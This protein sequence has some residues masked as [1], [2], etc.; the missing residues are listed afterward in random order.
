MAE[1]STAPSS[2]A[3]TASVNQLVGAGLES[4]LCTKFLA[5]IVLHDSLAEADLPGPPAAPTRAFHRTRALASK[6][7]N[8]G[9]ERLR[10]GAASLVGAGVAFA[11][12]VGS[13]VMV[14]NSPGSHAASGSTHQGSHTL[15]ASFEPP[16]ESPMAAHAKTHAS[17][18]RGVWAA[19]KTMGELKWR[20]AHG[21][22]AYELAFYRGDALAL[23]LT[24][25][26]TQLSVRVR[27]AGSAGQ[28][29]VRLAPGDY[30]WYVWPVI[31]GA[32]GPVAIVRA[33]LRLKA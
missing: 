21:A 8:L 7:P 28:G 26:R 1:G 3:S 4:W 14:A 12:V 18:S 13:G 20:K 15:A 17:L 5:Q 16:S 24:T 11:G 10:L 9:S 29:T 32:A 31:R 19:A 2:E 30:E 27:G 25:R 33:Q 6:R 22:S 23:R